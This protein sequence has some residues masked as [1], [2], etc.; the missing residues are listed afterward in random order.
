MIQ[1]FP[2]C[3]VR[4]PLSPPLRK[5]RRMWTC[6]ALW[7]L[8]ILLGCVSMLMSGCNEDTARSVSARDPKSHTSK[9]SATPAIGP[10]TVHP[11]N[12]RYFTDGSGRAIYLTGSHHW[13]NFQDSGE[14][15]QPL[16]VFDYPRYLDF[17]T[18]HRHNF[19]RMWVSEGGVNPTHWDP[20]PYTRIGPGTALDGKPRFDVAQFNQAYFDRLRSRVIAARDRGI[21]VGVMLFNGWSIYDHGYGTPWP[22][23]PFHKANNVNGIDGDPDGDGEG[24]EVH[25][26]QVPAITARQEAY[27]RKV[28]DTINDLDNVLYEITNETAMFSRDWQYHM[29]RFVQDYEK[30]K[31]KQHPVGMTDFDASPEEAGRVRTMDALLSSPADWI[32]PGNDGKVDFGNS[33]PPATGRKVVLSDTD[34]FFGIGGDHDWVWKTFVRGLNPI[35][36]DPVDRVTGRKQDPPGAQPARKAM[37]DTRAYAAR[38]NLASMVPGSD[39]CSTTFC[40][41]N[42]G[43]EYLAYLPFGSH[44]VEPWVTFLPRRL[45]QWTHSLNLFRRTVTVDLSAAPRLLEVEWFNPLTGETIAEGTTTGGSRRSFRAPFAGDAVL[46]LMAF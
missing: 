12:P 41:A 35:Y 33:P 1:P 16:S 31:P 20:L 34:H 32:S 37:G 27:V 7:L 11:T 36:M 28:V 6:V 21:Y 42:P 3:V 4:G 43:H 9:Q 15:G 30:T 23:H 8:P 25:A 29:I 22:F 5:T 18:S 39:I 10:L 40:L 14:I 24:K 13:N 45:Q 46:Y 19:M 2:V 26:L 44:W 17:L 38:I